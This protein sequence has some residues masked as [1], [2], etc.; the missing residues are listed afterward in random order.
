MIWGVCAAISGSMR[1]GMYICRHTDR[2]FRILMFPATLVSGI[3]PRF[4]AR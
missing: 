2:G 4:L 3:F 1:V